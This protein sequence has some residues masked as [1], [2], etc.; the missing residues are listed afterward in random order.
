MKRYGCIQVHN[1]PD[2]LVFSALVPKLFG[3]RIILDIHDLMPEFYA[4]SIDGDLS[5]LPVRIIMLEEQLSC[6]FADHVICVTENARQTLIDRDVPAEKISIVMNVADSK[7]F[8]RTTDQE[9]SIH[10][11]NHLRLVYHGTMTRRYGVDMLVKCVARLRN[12]IPGIQLTL[13]GHGELRDDL[14][15]LIK[16]LDVQQ[17][18]I[19]PHDLIPAAELPAILRKSDVGVVPNLDD[20]FTDGL[21]PTKLMEYVALG[22]PVVAA[23]TTTISAYFDDSMV[24]FFQPG[25]LDDLCAKIL[26]LFENPDLR[27]ELIKNSD[28]F[29]L[30]YSWENVAADYVAIVDRLN[31]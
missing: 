30:D 24:T 26:L 18:I 5:R 1:L 28:R 17:H 25:N 7:I 19:F 31:Q 20:L 8:F 11:G 21:L 16:E 10:N 6:R 22:I 27:I 29:N 14:L 15:V 23:E 12:Q 13:I 2:F 9:R 3:A 4:A